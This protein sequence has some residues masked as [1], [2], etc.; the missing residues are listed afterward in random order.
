MLDSTRVLAGHPAGAP[1]APIPPG[2]PAPDGW[3]AL[4]SADLTAWAGPWGISFAA[5][6]TPHETGIG[7]WTEQRFV[8]A[9]RTG[10]H[11]GTGRPILPPMPWESLAPATDT[12]L[13]AIYA[14]LRSLKPVENAVRGPVPPAHRP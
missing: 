9:M 8:Q 6:L 13:S 10:K 14:F 3:V 1:I 7:P 5:N 11:L 12:D 2:V 4:A